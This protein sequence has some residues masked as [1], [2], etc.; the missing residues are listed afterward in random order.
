MN[1]PT[2]RKYSC[3]PTF[4]TF[5]LFVKDNPD[6]SLPQSHHMSHELSNQKHATRVSKSLETII[7]KAVSRHIFAITESVDN[8]RQLT[9]F[10]QRYA[11]EAS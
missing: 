6:A 11:G 4:A 10:S 9:D 1:S 3:P 2:Y 8:V 5:V 7:S